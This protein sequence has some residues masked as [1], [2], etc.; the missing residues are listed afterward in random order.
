MVLWP[1]VVTNKALGEFLG[2]SWEFVQ[3]RA[4]ELGLKPRHLARANEA[5]KI[6]GQWE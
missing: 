1:T 5:K 3:Q 6:L 4:K 2:F